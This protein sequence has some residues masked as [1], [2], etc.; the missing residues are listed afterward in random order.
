MDK[1][2]VRDAL[3]TINDAIYELNNG[4]IDAEDYYWW[5]AVLTI[6]GYVV[7]KGEIVPE[8]YSDGRIV[9]TIC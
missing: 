6:F 3:D 5:N 4:K 9:G 2:K 7:D 8:R 1:V